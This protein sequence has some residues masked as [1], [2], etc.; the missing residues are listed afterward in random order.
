[1]SIVHEKLKICPKN[2]KGKIL[3][4]LLNSLEIFYNFYGQKW[5][6]NKAS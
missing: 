5:N 1:M 2:G 4:T 3:L 6:K